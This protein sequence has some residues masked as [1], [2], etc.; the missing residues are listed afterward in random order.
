MKALWTA[1]R[2]TVVMLGQFEVPRP[3]ARLFLSV[4]SGESVMRSMFITGCQSLCRFSV[5]P[6]LSLNDGIIH[7][8][9]VEGSFCTDTFTQ[10]IKRLLNHMQP[11]PAE[12]SVIVM[13]NCRIHK[14][15]EIQNMIESR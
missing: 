10:F 1:E 2:P 5:L 3:S 14:H 11:Y 7:C 13:D 12:N 15:P 9:I 6:A 8:D 4:V